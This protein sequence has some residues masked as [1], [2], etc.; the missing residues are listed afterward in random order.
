MTVFCTSIPVYPMLLSMLCQIEAYFTKWPMEKSILQHIALHDAIPADVKVA[1]VQSS[2]SAVKLEHCQAGELSSWSTVKLQRAA[3][4]P[5]ISFCSSILCGENKHNLL[6]LCYTTS[7]GWNWQTVCRS[8]VQSRKNC[9]LEQAK[10][11]F[12][13][14]WEHWKQVSSPFKGT[15]PHYSIKLQY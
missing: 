8:R 15:L 11:N 1:G 5:A 9:I 13:A 7:P 4:S 6:L 2:W 3:F 10:W 12:R 14:G